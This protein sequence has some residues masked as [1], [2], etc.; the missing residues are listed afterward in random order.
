V[1][2]RL[3]ALRASVERLERLVA[4]LPEA[5]LV[6]PAYPTEWTVADVLSHIGSSSV[7]WQR[8]VD[9]NLA[10]R[11]TPDDV[12]TAVWAEWDAKPPRSKVDDGI[13]ADRRFFDRLASLTTD[14][15]TRVRVTMGPIAFGFDDM[16]ATRLNEHVL[17]TWD[18]E[19]AGDAGAVLPSDA[20]EQIIDN[21]ALIARYTGRPTGASCT[22][23]VR[24]VGPAR[25]F[26]IT[27]APEAVDF[28]ATEDTDG[29]H[30]DLP[31]EAFV[32]LVYG[33]FDPPEDRVV[34][35]DGAVDELR[36]AFPG[37]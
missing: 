29:R 28:R 35:D 14:E 15:R 36:R 4:A 17:H 1:T 8:R 32:R 34:S 12:Q 33:R 21:L 11:A 20:V 27:L 9:D 18:V 7:I 6:A 23:V 3:D 5:D 10:D 26:S 25:V 24:T 2:A 31:A 19:V 22:I 37:L 16:V 30:V 13:A